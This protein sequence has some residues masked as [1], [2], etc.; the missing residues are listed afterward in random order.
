MKKICIGDKFQIQCY[1]HDGKIHR[2]WDE[3]VVLDIKKDYIVF[4]NNRTT[5][6][7]AQGTWWK[8]KE[9]AVMYF[10]KDKWFNIISQMKSDGIY[11]YCNIASPFIIE[12][13]TIKYIDYDLDLRIFPTGEYKILDRLEY[14][15]HRKIMQYSD[16]LD[17]V[18]NGALE[19]LIEEYKNNIPMFDSKK[20]KEYCQLYYQLIQEEKNSNFS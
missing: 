6:T 11:Y 5:V 13:G 18:V 8:T 4:G 2:A 12:E 14:E 9:P 3:A 1:K 15:Y 19:E 7:E 17:K 20:N 16:K 10:F